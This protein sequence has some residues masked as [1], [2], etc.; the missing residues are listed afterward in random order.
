MK[1]MNPFI[2]FLFPNKQ[3]Q[4][5]ANNNNK[6]NNQ[7]NKQKKRK[8]CFNCLRELVESHFA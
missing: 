7:S 4:T 8:Y 2:L 6:N 3:Q 1:Y 5:I